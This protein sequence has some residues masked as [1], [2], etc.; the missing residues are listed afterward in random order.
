M[1]RF[2]LM[3]SKVGIDTI[4]EEDWDVG[5]IA[6]INDPLYTSFDTGVTGQ[7]NKT[8]YL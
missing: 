2:D 1:F 4:K 3:D 7:Q 8:R 6:D 5:S